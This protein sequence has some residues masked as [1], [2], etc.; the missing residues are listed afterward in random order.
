MTN[1]KPPEGE[2]FSRLYIE[3]G[4]PVRDSP[5]LRKR[6]LAYLQ[7]DPFLSAGL[8]DIVAE[9]AREIGIPFPYGAATLDIAWLYGEGE[10][11]DVLDSITVV[12]RLAK[13]RNPSA[14]KNWIEFVRRALRE[15]SMWYSIDASGGVHF[16]IDEEYE[17]NRV[18][19]I[20]VLQFPQF[21]G[22]LHALES[23]YSRLDEEE[24]DTKS[25]IREHFR[26][27]GDA[28]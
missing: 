24:P 3:R 14:A 25:A 8:H 19:A 26:S 6:L 10:I 9:A 2:F 17:R 20:Q 15:E 4:T 11:R 7:Q 18:S 27:V 12:C 16:Y 22:V 21:A 23:A 1:D 13:Q 28:L 5:R